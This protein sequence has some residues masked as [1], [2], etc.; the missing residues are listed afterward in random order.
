[1]FRPSTLIAFAMLAAFHLG[2][3]T[4]DLWKERRGPTFDDFRVEPNF[5]GPA[6]PVDLSSYPQGRMYR[7]RLRE[8]AGRPPDFAGHYVVAEWGYGTS[9]GVHKL[10]DLA[11]GKIFDAPTTG[12]GFLHRV[13]S[14]LVIQDPPISGFAYQTASDLSPVVY[15]LWNGREFQQIYQEDCIVADK[16]LTC[17]AQ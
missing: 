5:A 4:A 3:Q 1:M 16:K 6:T 2:V 11:T 14:A 10:I 17:S 15:R 8:A 13:D 12:R 7:T 9:C